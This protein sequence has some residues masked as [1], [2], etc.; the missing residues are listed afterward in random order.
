VVETAPDM[1]TRIDRD[2]RYV[3]VNA[4]FERAQ[5]VSSDQLLG[6]LAGETDMT[7]P[8]AETWRLTLRQV[9]ASGREQTVELPARVAGQERV[10]QLRAAPELGP[11]GRVEHI[12]AVGRDV[13][14]RARREEEQARLYRELMERDERLH[15]LARRALLAHEQEQRRLRGLAELDQLTRREQETLRLLARGLTTRQIA[16]QLAIKPGTAKSYIEHVLAKLGV[17]NRTQAAARAMELGLLEGHPPADT[18]PGTDDGA[19][20]EPSL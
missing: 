7:P 12:V 8:V 6:R 20:T 2:L 14:E 10:L 18:P 13:T 19:R 5:G 4:A 16:E 1:V 11:D 9:F 3:Y 15:A 17:G